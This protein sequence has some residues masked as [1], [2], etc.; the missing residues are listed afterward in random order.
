MNKSIYNKKGF[1][2][3]ELLIAVSIIAIIS[4][5]G[6]S[7]FSQSQV[8]ARDSK[9]K[10]DL[11][12]IAVALELYKQKNSRYPC[13]G[14][15]NS[16]TSP[17]DWV[18]DVNDP[19]SFGAACTGGKPFDQNFINTLPK[20]PINT[21]TQPWVTNNYVYGYRAN[22]CGQNGLHYWLVAQLENTNDPD[23]IAVSN[24]KYCDGNNIYPGTITVPNTFVIMSSD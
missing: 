22:Q 9:R 21:G 14:W 10:S 18:T 3:L 16:N 19:A 24:K 17:T 15:R 5:V 6:F 12:S 23:Q 7:T 1:S 4:A 13:A 2:L 20:D 11:R 8:R